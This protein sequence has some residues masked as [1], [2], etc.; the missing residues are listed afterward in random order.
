MMHRKATT[1][2]FTSLLA[3]GRAQQIGTQDAET[4]P[5]IT[6]Q[7]CTSANQCSTINGELVIDS[8]WRWTHVVGGYQNCYDGNDWNRTACPN[9]EQCAQNCAVEGANYAGTYG[10]TTSGNAVTMKFR[11]DHQYGSNIGSRLY[12]MNGAEKYQMFTTN[13]NEI[14]FDV[15]NADLG[16]GLNGA[17]YFVSMDED[18]GKARYPTNK[19]GAKYGTGYCDSQCARDL[20]WVG[21]KGNVEGWEP[22]STDANTGVGNAGACCAEMDLW[23]AN[24]MSFALTPHPCQQEGYFVCQTSDCGG[25][26]S[27]DR[28]AGTCDPDGCDLNPF[29]H[30][31]TD[32]YGK[33]KTVDTSRKFTVV[34]RFHGSGTTLNSLSQYFI[35][36]GRKIDVPGS[37]YV[38]G[39]STIDSEFCEASK[40]IFKDNKRFQELGGLSQMGKATGTPMVLVLSVWDDGYSNMLW[41]DGQRYPLDR[42]P[43]EPG[44]PRGECD[45]NGST[46]TIV[47]E[48]F[49]DAKVTYSNFK[50][51]PIGSTYNF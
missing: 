41:L 44:V 10:V 15:E 45:V 35:Q 23:E 29:R 3:L 46:P 18:G 16:C 26:Y 4:H 6:W 19:A 1:V 51:G 11:N 8:N 33:G 50:F 25:T 9:N 21:G 39:G 49:K 22:S 2:A 12:L 28:Y 38:S 5:A 43:S 31:N 36:D 14:A 40:N 24:S 7:Q 17:V 42:D 48:K 37:K 27:G 47:R 20:K 32:F 34:T 13:G 30:G